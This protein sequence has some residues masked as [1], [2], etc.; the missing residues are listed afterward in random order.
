MDIPENNSLF[1]KLG[2]TKSIT[3]ELS[4]TSDEFKDSFKS[5]V[6]SETNF[7]GFSGHKL[8]FHGQ[9]KQSTF[10]IS[11]SSSYL[12]NADLSAATGSFQTDND[13]VVIEVMAHAPMT[14]IVLSS[15]IILLI[16]VIPLIV[17][18]NQPTGFIP[19]IIIC[20][21]TLLVFFPLFVILPHV[22]KLKRFLYDLE[23]EFT[24]W[25][26]KSLK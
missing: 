22:R 6:G 26:L 20:S 15:I 11:R 1:K 14:W 9:I 5:R 10:K 24:T 18:A 23:R 8:E 21:A 4:M 13:K 19:A 25:Q 2:L 3:V 17:T 7:F 12:N 16:G